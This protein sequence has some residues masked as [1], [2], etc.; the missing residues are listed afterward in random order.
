LEQFDPESVEAL[1]VASFERMAA[2]R[3]AD[4]FPM[5]LNA[6]IVTGRVM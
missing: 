2:L 3:A 5:H 1:R 4:G 6:W